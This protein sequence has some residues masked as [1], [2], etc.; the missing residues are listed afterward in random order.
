MK[1]IVIY[2]Q[3]HRLKNKVF[4]SVNQ[5]LKQSKNNTIMNDVDYS[6]FT[7]YFMQLKSKKSTQLVVITTN[8]LFTHN[9]SFFV[10]NAPKYDNENF[11]TALKFAL[12]CVKTQ[13]QINSLPNVQLK[14]VEIL[15]NYYNTLL[16]KHLS[17]LDAENARNEIYYKRAQNQQKTA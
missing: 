3:N 13:M 17:W 16:D 4:K 15:K 8:R 6:D 10:V 9:N 11:S 1:P 12:Q 14:D 7:N 2:C 5:F